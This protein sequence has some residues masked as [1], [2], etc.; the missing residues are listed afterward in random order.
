MGG[1]TPPLAASITPSARA[2]MVAGLSLFDF[3]ITE[4]L[5]FYPSGARARRTSPAIVTKA[6]IPTEMLAQPWPINPSMTMM[7][8]GVK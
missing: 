1:T 4:V 3:A 2:A 5:P 7:A 8:P 6:P